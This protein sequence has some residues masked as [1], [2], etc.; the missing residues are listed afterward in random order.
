MP[1]LESFESGDAVGA[2]LQP[3]NGLLRFS[4]EAKYYEELAPYFLK[5]PLNKDSF[6]IPA[7]NLLLASSG[8]P[9]QSPNTQANLF[10]NY[11]ELLTEILIRLPYQMKKLCLGSSSQGSWSLS[12]QFWPRRNFLF[13]RSNGSVK[14]R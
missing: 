8:L 11:A 9:Q 10:D 5:D 3:P 12:G 4:C 13:A 6:L 7:P 1:A 2:I 14:K